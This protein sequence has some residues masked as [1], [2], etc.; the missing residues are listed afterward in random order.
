MEDHQ[1]RWFEK[2]GRQGGVVATS[3]TG[4]GNRR[5]RLTV[6]VREM[7]GESRDGA[8]ALMVATCEKIN[9][10][11]NQCSRGRSRPGVVQWA[12]A[13]S[14]SLRAI[15]LAKSGTWHLPNRSNPC[16]CMKAMMGRIFHPFRPC[17]TKKKSAV[18][19]SRW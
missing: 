14:L 16:A 9:E 5:F 6:A 1:K 13:H 3:G 7:S 2:G 17:P 11:D 18:T 15:V 19:I 8:M 12:V 4:E 10:E